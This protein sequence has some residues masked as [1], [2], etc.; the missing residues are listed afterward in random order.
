MAEEEAPEEGAE[1]LAAGERAMLAPRPKPKAV[2]AAAAITAA[3]HVSRQIHR[4]R[5]INNR[6]KVM[7]TLGGGDGEGLVRR[8]TII[9]RLAVV[10]RRNPLDRTLICSAPSVMHSPCRGYSIPEVTIGSSS[11]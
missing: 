11:H 5:R 7:I 1:E 4:C 9:K 8:P 3:I 2:V 6:D 10:Y